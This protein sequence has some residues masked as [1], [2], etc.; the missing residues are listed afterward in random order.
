MEKWLPGFHLKSSRDVEFS[1][2]P[3]ISFPFFENKV[4]WLPFM[5]LLDELEIDLLWVQ[6]LE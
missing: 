5:V 2:F 4:P 1:T 3:G 6:K